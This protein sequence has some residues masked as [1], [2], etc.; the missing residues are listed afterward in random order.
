MVIVCIIWSHCVPQ[1]LSANKTPV[2]M[3]QPSGVTNENAVKWGFE[4]QIKLLE[5][6]DLSNWYECKHCKMNVWIVSLLFVLQS[7]HMY[8]DLG[9]FT[10]SMI[11]INTF[12]PQVFC[13]FLFSFI[14]RL[15]AWL[16]LGVQLNPNTVFGKAQIVGF[17]EY[18]FCT[19]ILEMIS[20]GKEKKHV[21]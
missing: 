7:L 17:Y 2:N 12:N 4:F 1:S 8:S 3:V 5:S 15:T 20:F 16:L 19:N 6:T 13:S 9:I 21:R 18:L 10:I 11:V 14:C